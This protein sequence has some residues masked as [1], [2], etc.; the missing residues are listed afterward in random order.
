MKQTKTDIL[1]IGGGTSG[2]CAGIQAARLGANVLLVEPTPWLGG[3]LT[4]AGVSAIDGNHRL[5]SGLWGEFRQRLYD[6]Y[7]GA[8]AVFTGWVSNTQFEPKVGAQILGAMAAAEKTLSVMHGYRVQSLQKS[9]HRVTGAMIVGPDGNGQVVTAK[10]T[11]DATEYGDVLAM[12]GCEYD[13]GRDARSET[14]EAGAAEKID[15]AIQDLTYVAILQAYPDGQAPLVPK[16]AN[17]DPSRFR[18]CCKEAGPDPTNTSCEAMISYGRL[19]NDKYMINWP[20]FGNDIF[21]PLTEM[22]ERERNDALKQAKEHTLAFVYFLQQELGQR[23]LGL[24]QD[25]FPTAD[26][27]PLIPYIRESRRLR[28]VQ[29]LLVDDLADPYGNANRA[30]YRYGIAVGDYPLDHHHDQYPGEVKESYASLPAFNV[31]YG[32]LVPKEIDGLLVAEKSISV[33]HLVN[34]CTRLQPVVMG[35]GQAAGAAAALS[36][37]QQKQPREMDVAILQE[38]LLK[39][40]CMLMPFSDVPP[41]HDDFKIAQRAGLGG[42]LHGRGESIDWANR[43]YFDPDGVLTTDQL[44]QALQAANYD[45]ADLPPV[46]LNRKFTRLEFARYM[47]RVLPR[48]SGLFL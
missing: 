37:E 29:R 14:G 25:E 38:T 34:G 47:D 32:C 30:L 2:V 20:R 5:P 40:N 22:N 19:P 4:A 35:I 28:G 8:E 26:A 9:E 10:I 24:A 42:T 17:Y 33:T 36:I 44:K 13:L 16:P 7:G 12:A 6:H 48:R 31:P 15:D 1:I 45:K 43:M 21:L 41:A 23:H 46:D 3:M 11:I 27:L 18:G 39:A